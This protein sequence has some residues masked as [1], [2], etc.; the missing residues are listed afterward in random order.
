MEGSRFTDDTINIHNTVFPSSKNLG[1]CIQ[2][3]LKRSENDVDKLLRIGG[4]IRLVKGAYNESPLVAYKS[5]K[6]IDKNYVRLMKRLFKDNLSLFSIA[7]HDD[8][9]IYETK[10]MNENTPRASSSHY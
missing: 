1:I 9:L 6:E 2:S 3:Y 10:R 7:T 4:K 5:R 8:K